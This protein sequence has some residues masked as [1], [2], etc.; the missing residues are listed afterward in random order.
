MADSILPIKTPMRGVSRRFSTKLNREVWGYDIRLH[1]RR[2]RY[3]GYDTQEEAEEVVKRQKFE[4][5]RQKEQLIVGD[6]EI[7]RA[8]LPAVAKGCKMG[9]VGACAEMVVCVDLLRR[10]YDIFRSV[11]PNSECDLIITYRGRICRVEVKSARIRRGRTEFSQQRL[12]KT[13]F[14]MLALVFLRENEI[15]YQPSPAAF[16]ADL[17]VNPQGDHVRHSC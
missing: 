13:K 4:E 17:D 10:G 2:F 3:Y 12:N 5:Y 14:D 1:G 6:P 11:S 7:V 8:P 16:F 15:Y 9:S